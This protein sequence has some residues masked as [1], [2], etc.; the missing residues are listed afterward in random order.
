MALIFNGTTV[1][2]NVA[3]ALIYNG[4]SITKVVFN[5]TIVWAQNSFQA[6]WSGSSTSGHWY[7]FSMNTSGNLLRYTNKYNTGAWITA[8]TSG[9]F[10]GNSLVEGGYTG[11]ITS[12]NLLRFRFY[13]PYNGWADTANWCT[14]TI[15]NK[16][17]T[18]TSWSEYYYNGGYQSVTHRLET[19]GGL[20]RA[21]AYSATDGRGGAWISLT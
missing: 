17:W 9:T 4:T 18:G 8:T 7:Y 2:S 16:Q 21:I 5:S 11:F 13:A 6:K 3:N 1:P 20:I 10:V 19:S 15:A 12:S 14:Y